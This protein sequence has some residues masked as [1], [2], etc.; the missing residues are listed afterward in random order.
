MGQFT[1]IFVDSKNIKHKV[2]IQASTWRV[3]QKRFEEKY[4]DV[5]EVIS[6]KKQS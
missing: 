6:A 3:A 2:W 1:F 4:T 5:K